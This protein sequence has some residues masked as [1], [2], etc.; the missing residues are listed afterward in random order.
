MTG[1]S[2]PFV[3]ALSL[4]PLGAGTAQSLTI[5]AATSP[6]LAARMRSM[7]AA[8]PGSAFSVSKSSGR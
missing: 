6:S 5:T 4:L 1:R 2:I 7:S 3:V 8:S